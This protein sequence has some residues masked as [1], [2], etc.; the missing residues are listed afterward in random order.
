MSPTGP[1][2]HE[3]RLTCKRCGEVV[4]AKTAV[5]VH[6]RGYHCPACAAADAPKPAA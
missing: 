2:V 6:L 1:M 5:Y 3:I 4:P